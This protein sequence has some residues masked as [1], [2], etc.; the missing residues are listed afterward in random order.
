MRTDRP[1]TRGR[2]FFPPFTESFSTPPGQIASAAQANLALAAADM[3]D[4]C[5]IDT[6]EVY[7]GVISPYSGTE[8]HFFIFRNGTVQPYFCTQRRRRVNVGS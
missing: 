3:L 1:Q 4:P 7:P 8:A 2:K 6:I 5:T